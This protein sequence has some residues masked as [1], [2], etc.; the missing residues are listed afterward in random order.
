MSQPVHRLYE[1]GPYRLNSAQQVLSEG[2]RRIPLTPKAFQTLLVL[3]EAQGRVVAKD[4]LL[5][6]VW[7]D[8][9]VEEATLAQNVFTL[10]K[11]LENQRGTIYIETVP[12]KGYRFV[13]PVRIA[14]PP[15]HNE[16]ATPILPSI[17]GKSRTWS[18]LL[19]LLGTM[20][21]IAAIAF[22]LYRLDGSKIRMNSSGR[23]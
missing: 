5:Q 6:K 10:R 11:Q 4:E 2:K 16:S 8:T 18:R 7:P 19:G 1:F 13:A 21:L 22:L 12:K 23:V 9:F 3:V 17:Q 20:V 15:A 14:E